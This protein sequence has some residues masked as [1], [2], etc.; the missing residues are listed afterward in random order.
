MAQ[1]PTSNNQ[2][3]TVGARGMDRKATASCKGFGLNVSSE[4]AYELNGVVDTSG[5]K[6][7]VIRGD[8]ER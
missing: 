6:D 2:K 7:R 4:I 3:M 5:A 8:G 1:L